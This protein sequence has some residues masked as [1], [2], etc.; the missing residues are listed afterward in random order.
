MGAKAETA[1]AIAAVPHGLDAKVEEELFQMMAGAT[2]VLQ[3]AGCVLT[4]GHTCEAEQ[5]S[6]GEA[7]CWPPVGVGLACC[8]S[9]QPRL[10]NKGTPGWLT[11]GLY[12]ST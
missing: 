12:A 10:E 5:L 2:R 9:I 7:I 4:G 8:S 11:E 1:L 6:L 3:D